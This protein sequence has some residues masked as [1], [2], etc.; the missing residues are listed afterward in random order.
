[1]ENQQPPLRKIIHID[2]DAFYASVEQRDFPAYSGK[3]LAVGGSRER[4]VVAAASYEA[5]KYGIHSAM[6]SATAYR[7]CPHIIF[8]KPRFEVYK[9]ISLKIRQLFLAYTELIEPLSLDEAYLDVTCDKLKIGSATLIAR[10]IKQQ[11]KEETGLTASA[12]VSYNKFLAKIASDYDKPDG[13]KVI[14]PNQASEFLEKLPVEKFHG[15]GKVTARKMHSFNIKSGSDLKNQSLSFLKQHFGKAGHFY[16]QIVRGMDTRAV[17]P[18]R[19]R[20]SIGTERTFSQ[21]L[22]HFTELEAELEEIL[23]ELFQRLEKQKITGSTL[24]LKVKYA[25]FTTITRS[26]TT[27]THF[28]ERNEIR[29]IAKKL[30]FSIE[31][32]G[33]AIRLLGLA[34]SKLNHQKL[35]EDTIQLK[36]NFGL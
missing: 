28:K 2:M 34:L 32:K 22:H 17:N 7:L 19:I 13:L 5:R 9:A 14:L 4:G 27:Q 21:D 18:H 33:R 23:K 31:L 26:I 36:L 10:Q 3:P 6:P 20:K 11:I 15:I 25:D 16:Y 12:G 8:V 30:M 24:T 29:N 35:Q 1:M